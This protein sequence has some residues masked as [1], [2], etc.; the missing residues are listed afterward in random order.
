MHCFVAGA[1]IALMMLFVF[2][3]GRLEAVVAAQAAA[4]KRLEAALLRDRE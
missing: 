4:F 3:L 2:G 1:V